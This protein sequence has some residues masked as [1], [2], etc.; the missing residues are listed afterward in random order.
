MVALSARERVLT[1]DPKYSTN[2]P[3]TFLFLSI[4]VQV[5][6]KS[7]AVAVFGNYPVSLKPT[8]Y[9]NTIEI[10]SPIITDSASIPPTPQPKTPKP[11]I[12]VVCESVP[13]T[14]SGY[15]SPSLSKTTLAKYSKFT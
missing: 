2:F 15:N 1:P 13:T 3:T 9:G 8:T 12:I 10:F 6:T 5:R 7:V 4:S 14:E 11:L